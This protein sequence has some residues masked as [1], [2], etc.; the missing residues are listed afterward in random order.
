MG[1][2]LSSVTSGVLVMSY[3]IV[4]LF[5]LRFWHETRDRLFGIF[6]A[7]FWMLAVQRFLLVLLE[8]TPREDVWLYALRLLAFVLILV[9]IID[10]NRAGA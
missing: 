10:K 8:V 1:D 3:L 4:G 6:A 2:A 7:A 9:A 5:F